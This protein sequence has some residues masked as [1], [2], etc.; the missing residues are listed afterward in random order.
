MIAPDDP[1]RKSRRTA[2]FTHKEKLVAVVASETMGRR[3]AA[4]LVG[5]SENTIKTWRSDEELLPYLLEARRQL[6]AQVAEASTKSWAET[7]H[8]LN[9]E[10][11]AIPTRDLLAI[12]SEST[13]KFQLLSGQA[14]SRS[15]TRD[16]TDGIAD[17]EMRV[18]V[19]EARRYLERHGPSARAAMVTRGRLEIPATTEPDATGG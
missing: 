12:A 5:A 10:P 19:N 8:R 18:L 3:R 7:L 6:M 14:T 17:D 2:G 9:T 1:R 4:K 11:E 15:E 16:V 13:N